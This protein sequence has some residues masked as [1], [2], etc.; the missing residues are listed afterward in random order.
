MKLEKRDLALLYALTRYGILSTEQIHSKFFPGVAKTTMHRRL[1]ILMREEMIRTVQGLPGA[2]RA[3]VMTRYGYIA[4]G[5]GDVPPKFSNQN[6]IRHEVRLTSVRMRLEELGL[7]RDLNFVPEWELKRKLAENSIRAAGEKQVPDGIL[8]SE[9]HGVSIGVALELE[10]T[11]KGWGRYKEMR[12]R[13][14]KWQPKQ[15]RANSMQIPNVKYRSQIR[16]LSRVL[17]DFYSKREVPEEIMFE[18]LEER[19]LKSTKE[20]KA[21]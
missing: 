11:A 7:G 8:I 19:M 3:W 21:A 10:L 1:R 5:N 13:Q 17:Y 20:R 15:I 4:T 6:T 12:K 14:T 18:S 16:E 9:S 2:E